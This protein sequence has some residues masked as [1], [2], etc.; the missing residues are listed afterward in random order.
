MMTTFNS[1]ID[2]HRVIME[3]LPAWE[4]IKYSDL[5]NSVEEKKCLTERFCKMIFKRDLMGKKHKK[6]WRNTIRELSKCNVDYL[7]LFFYPDVIYEMRQFH[8]LV[9]FFFQIFFG[10][11]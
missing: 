10:F 1:C 11:Y 9:F 5:L 6:K 8:V 2:L 3:Y 7:F 4:I